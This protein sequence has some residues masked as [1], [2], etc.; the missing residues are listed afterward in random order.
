MSWK[1]LGVFVAI[2]AFGT[3]AAAQ[4]NPFLGVWQLNGEK[5]TNY[6]QQSQ[7]IINVPTSDGFTSIRSTIGKDNRN[8]TE[9]HP[10]AF[11]GKPH[12]TTG[13]DVREISYKRIDAYTVERTHNRN[14]KISVDTEQV[15]KDGKTL[16]VKQEN[17]LRVYDKI[18]D[19]QPVGRK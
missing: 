5:T 12:A 17:A 11:D 10:V 7:L 2:L 3:S 1:S 4:K 6:Q 19:V 16:T 18:A 8:S 15:S 13:G 14:G 9:V